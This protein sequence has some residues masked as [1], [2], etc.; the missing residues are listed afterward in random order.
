M[1]SKTN[2]RISQPQFGRLVASFIL[3]SVVTTSHLSFM[4]MSAIKTTYKSAN[5]IAYTFLGGQL[6]L[7]LRKSLVVILLAFIRFHQNTESAADPVHLLRYGNAEAQPISTPPA[8]KPF[9]SCT[10]LIW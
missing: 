5:D 10:A 1:G 8:L 9:H 7:R 3:Q 2:T 4:A 6:R